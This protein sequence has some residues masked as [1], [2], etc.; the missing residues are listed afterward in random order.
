MP[1]GSNLAACLR[2]FRLNELSIWLFL[3]SFQEK[4]K[5]E[6]E[7]FKKRLRVV[8]NNLRTPFT[9]G[10]EA[11]VGTADGATEATLAGSEVNKI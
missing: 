11:Q 6:A 1:Q 8:W 2:G 4:F 3:L 5:K 7:S 10:A 9:G